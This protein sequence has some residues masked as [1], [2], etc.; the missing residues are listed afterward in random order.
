MEYVGVKRRAFDEHW[1][2]HLVALPQGTSLI[3]DREDLDRLFDRFKQVANHTLDRSPADAPPEL[4]GPMDPASAASAAVSSQ[5]DRR[6]TSGKGV[7]KWV[8]KV[9]SIR[10]QVAGG[11][12]TSSTAVNAFK[13]VSD[14]IRKPKLG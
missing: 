7:E 14:R 2:P 8:V 3:F 6:P 10:T 13:A 11:E 1:R 4:P 12:S 9:A 5:V